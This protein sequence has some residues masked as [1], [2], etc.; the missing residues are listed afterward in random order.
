MNQNH[1]KVI[2]IDDDKTITDSLRWLCESISLPVK[3]YGCTKS[4]LAHH[5]VNERGC[6]IV[7][8]RMPF[9]SGLELIEHLNTQKSSLATI[10]MTAYGD[11]PMAVR[12]MKAGAVDF[13]Q[14][15]FNAQALLE[16]VQKCLNKVQDAKRTNFSER[17][18]ELTKRERQVLD[19][20]LEGKLNKE[21]AYELSIAISTVEAHRAK[22][23][24]KMHVKTL[25]QLM[26]FCFN[27]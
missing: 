25:G 11:I 7:D 9:M 1:P 16:T 5:D 17:F 3:T 18:N 22:I 21:I 10:V 19:L 23:M 6:L 27:N 13:V 14:K 2:I 20:I 26:R 4:Y 15:P 24:Q 8:V 12:A